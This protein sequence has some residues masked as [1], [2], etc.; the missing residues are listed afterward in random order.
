MKIDLDVSMLEPCEPLERTLEA[1]QALLPGQYLRVVHRREPK[2]L[3]PML[4]KAGFEWRCREQ[5]ANLF[6][7][8]IWRNGD[9]E[10]EAEMKMNA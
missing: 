3:Y 8:Y 2:L 9:E 10:A 1:I 5:D 4:E 6:N 7:I